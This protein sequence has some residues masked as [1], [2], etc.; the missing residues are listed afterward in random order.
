MPWLMI[1]F[2]MSV[3]KSWAALSSCSLRMRLGAPFFS[4]EGGYKPNASKSL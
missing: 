4:T 3:I 1:S 2:L